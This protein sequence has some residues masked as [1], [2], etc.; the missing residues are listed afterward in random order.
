VPPSLNP[1][2]PR[3]EHSE[4]DQIEPVVLPVSF[5]RGLGFEGLAEGYGFDARA[6]LNDFEL[7]VV[8]GSQR[9]KQTQC[10]ELP[11]DF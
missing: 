6:D 8:T 2:L 1:V 5:G 11:V 10:L 9:E 7:Q 4:A 3:S